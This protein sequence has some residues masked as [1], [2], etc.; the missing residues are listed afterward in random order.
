MGGGRKLPSMAGQ[1]LVDQEMAR[2]QV[3][4]KDRMGRLSAQND[5]L[6]QTLLNSGQKPYRS[7]YEPEALIDSMSSQ[8][9]LQQ[10]NLAPLRAFGPLSMF[11]Q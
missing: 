3:R 2:S 10:N 5:E 8:Q 11:D 6:F 7:A 4:R 9:T 1:D